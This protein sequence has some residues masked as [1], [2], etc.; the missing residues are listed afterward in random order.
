MALGL[1]SLIGG[2]SGAS[3]VSGKPISSGLVDNGYMEG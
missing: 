1:P 2:L 3:G